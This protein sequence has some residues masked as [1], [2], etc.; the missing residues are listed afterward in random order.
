MVSLRE[1]EVKNERERERKRTDVVA[2]KEGDLLVGR[3]V[4]EVR[5][6][7]SS[8]VRVGVRILS[9]TLEEIGA[10]DGSLM[11]SK[12]KARSARCSISLDEVVCDED[13]QA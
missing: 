11:K 6:S 8:A 4:S 2:S 13:S 12:R 9:S 5:A 10:G 3:T 7:S 1:R